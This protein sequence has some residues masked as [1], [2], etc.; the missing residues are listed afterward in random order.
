MPPLRITV[1][2][3]EYSGYCVSAI[4][5]TTQQPFDVVATSNGQAMWGKKGRLTASKNALINLTLV[6]DSPGLS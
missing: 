3:L 4:T 5:L 6:Y 1:T 2:L